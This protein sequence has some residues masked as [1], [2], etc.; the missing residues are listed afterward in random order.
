MNTPIP[1]RSMRVGARDIGDAPIVASWQ[2]SVGCGISPAAREAP[3]AATG[4]RFEELRSRYR[5]LRNAASGIFT[6][7]RDLLIDSRSMMLLTSADGIVLDAAGSTQTLDEGERIHLMPGGDWREAAIGTNG[8]GMALATR[9]PA[10]VHGDEHFCEVVKS[11]TCAAAPV[12]EPWTGAILGVLDISGPPRTYHRNN[13]TLAVAATRQI[14]TALAGMRTQERTQ[15]LE[16]C[17][18]RLSL[19][20]AEGLIAID[21]RGCLVH[22]S[23]RVPLAAGPMGQSIKVGARMPGLD[24]DSTLETWSSRLPHGL[25]PEW[26][27]PVVV[28]G[29]PIG[30]MLV[31]PAVGSRRVRAGSNCIADRS[32]EADPQ[33]SSFASIEG[34]SASLRS[35]IERARQLV[36]KCVPVLIEGETGVG[37]ELFARA[38]HGEE[39]RISPFITFNCAATSQ[40]LVGDQLFGHVR[41]AFT[42]ATTEGRAGR[43]ELADGGTLC[44]DEIGDMPLALQPVLLR[45]LEEGVIY[46]LGDSQPRHVNVRLLALTNRNLL[47][48]V[49]AGRFR[50][51][52]Y[53]RISV[54]RLRVPPLRERHADIELLVERFN[55][56]SAQ[57]HAVPEKR[58]GAQVMEL[59][60]AYP[61]PGNIRELRN[62]IESLVLT[63]REIEVTVEDLP[64]E[65]RRVASR[66][67]PGAATEP[68]L[69]E[70]AS[71]DDVEHRAVKQALEAGRGN[72]TQAARGLGISRSTLYRKVRRYGLDARMKPA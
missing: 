8:I 41:G 6:A 2:R 17:L 33:R 10:Q 38:L 27:H 37:K 58:F 57:R 5:E 28:D 31:V 18:E 69:R 34:R 4:S 14:E 13:L 62:V 60:D 44:L 15:L 53:H 25:R 50:R 36:G 52:L 20:D 40:E 42:G 61:W 43:F 67:R 30:A 72:L 19:A 56:H 59:L 45:A 66:Q 12:C 68:L 49:E 55:R 16:A 63:G 9:A 3:V 26:L 46:R 70:A 29:D 64:E 1:E 22:V 24:P 35:A 47:E 71:L 48:E 7:T 39:R 65:V 51:D 23:G 11:W 21:R 32:S 54:T